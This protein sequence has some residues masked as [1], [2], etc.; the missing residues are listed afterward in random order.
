MYQPYIERA[1]ALSDMFIYMFVDQNV[2][3]IILK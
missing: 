3:G 1:P 2:F